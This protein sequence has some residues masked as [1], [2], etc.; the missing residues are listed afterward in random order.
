MKLERNG[1]DFYLG[2]AERSSDPAT[3]QLFRD[4]AADEVDHYNYIGRQ[5]DAIAAGETWVPIPQL[6][7]VKAVDS[8]APIF[9][10]GLNALEVLPD[11]ATDQDALLFALGAEMQS[12]ELYSQSSDEADNAAARQLFQALASAEQQH[13]NLIMARYETLFGYPR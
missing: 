13:F 5:Y 9:P 2:A 4:L 7:E 8:K 10:A 1:L 6:E 12:Y 3:A 11:D